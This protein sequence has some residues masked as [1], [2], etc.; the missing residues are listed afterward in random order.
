MTA[1]R[2]RQSPPPLPPV[3]IIMKGKK[4]PETP[5]TLAGAHA[6][7]NLQFWDTAV[8]HHRPTWRIFL[9][10]MMP[11]RA[12]Q[13]WYIKPPFLDGCGCARVCTRVHG[14]PVLLS[15]ERAAV[16]PEA[17]AARDKRTLQLRGSPQ[18]DGT[19]GA[20]KQSAQACSLHHTAAQHHGC[21]RLGTKTG[22]RM[23]AWRFKEGDE[24]LQ[25]SR[26][27]ETS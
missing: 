22:S 21:V 8:F 14:C 1:P 25:E 16:K 27:P 18:A 26:V 23:R 20:A 19:A 10:T 12:F 9:V 5:I 6:W 15:S 4:T 17:R 3:L 7:N 24:Y 2:V 11:E 13:K